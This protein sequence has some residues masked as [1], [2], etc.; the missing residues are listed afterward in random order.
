MSGPVAT[1]VADGRDVDLADLALDGIVGAGGQ[2]R[3]HRLRGGSD[4][5]YKEYL[6]PARVQAAALTELVQLRRGLDGTARGALDARSAWPLARVLA[7]GRCTGF[8]MR[9][10]PDNMLWETGAGS[11]K[12]TELQYLLHPERPAT[13]GVVRPTPKQRLVLVRAV[14]DLLAG[15]HRHG[16]VVGDLSQANVLWTVVPEP[17]VF[18]I[19]CDGI[20]RSGA[21]PVLEQAETPDWGDPLSP[22]GSDAT[23]DSDRYKAALVVG[24]VLAQQAYLAPGD[25]LVPLP[26]VL[27]DRQDAAVRRLWEQAAGPFGSRPELPAWS[28]ALDARDVIP[29]PRLRPPPP[30]PVD[31]S[32]FDDRRA[33]RGSV[34]L[35]PTP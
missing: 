33:P 7:A 8:L 34:R 12:P 19:D 21:R 22:F 26:G 35:P 18:L 3:I 13:A 10:A 5:L 16:L 14:V 2:G 20:R 23:V 9:T 27:N 17:A 11:R 30:R 15:L 4:L 6:E 32:L 24:R 31:T 25:P 29:V 28:A 1:A